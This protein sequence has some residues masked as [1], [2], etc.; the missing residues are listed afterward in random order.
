MREGATFSILEIVPEAGSG[1]IGYY[2]DGEEPTAGWT[3]EIADLGSAVDRGNYFSSAASGLFTQLTNAGLMSTGDDT[4]LTA[5][6]SSVYTERNVWQ[7]TAGMK[8][9]YLTHDEHSEVQGTFAT[10]AAGSGPYR[11]D[12]HYALHT[13]G[14]HVQ[15]IACFSHGDHGMGT[16]YYYNPVFSAPLTDFAALTDG[17]AV[18]VLSSEGGSTTS[19]TAP[20][21]TRASAWRSEKRIMSSRAPARRRR[22]MTART[23]MRPL[24]RTASGRLHR[25]AAA[26]STASP[27]A[28]PMWGGARGY[29]LYARHDRRGEDDLL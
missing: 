28:T 10:G 8:A 2:I 24:P 13:G 18:Y 27:T 19:I 7:N 14:D 9:L 12:V 1:S 4:P 15:N 11:E 29:H 25:P 6:G 5:P 26:T 20:S 16:Y 3:S 21:G 22:P 17:T 23:P